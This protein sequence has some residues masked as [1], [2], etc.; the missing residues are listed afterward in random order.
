M[1]LFPSD[2]GNRPRVI[3]ASANSVIFCARRIWFLG[4][5]TNQARAQPTR[6][7]EFV[8]ITE[9]YHD[10]AKLLDSRREPQAGVPIPPPGQRQGR[11]CVWAAIQCGGGKKKGTRFVPG[12]QCQSAMV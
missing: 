9:S 5:Q 2:L 7:A 8:A 4:R 12:A 11:K 10:L 1:K 3:G 6:R